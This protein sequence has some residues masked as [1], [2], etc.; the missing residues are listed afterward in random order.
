MSCAPAVPA[1]S[2]FNDN[3]IP[4]IPC[5]TS[6]PPEHRV[7]VAE[8]G[9][10][11]NAMVMRPV[12]RKEMISNPKAMEAFMKAWKGLWDQEVFDFFKPGNTMMW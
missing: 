8:H 9:N 12:T 11:F 2:V 4:A 6:I 5:T 10:C 3:W 1:C 7:K